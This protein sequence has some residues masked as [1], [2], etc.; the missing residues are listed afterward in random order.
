[1]SISNNAT[2]LRPGVC[3]SSTRPTTPYEGQVIYETDTDKVLIWN[4]SAW[5]MLNQKTQN[6]EGLELIDVTPLTSGSSKTISAFSSTYD[7]YRVVI[8]FVA[9]VA[10]SAYAYVRL[11]G[12]A[13]NH[14]MSGEYSTWNSPTRTGDNGADGYAFLF[15]TAQSSA[16][17]IDIMCPNLAQYSYMF[18]QGAGAD[19]TSTTRI[20]V[21]NTTQYTSYDF[22]LGGSGTFTSGNIV[23]YGYRKAI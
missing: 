13:T 16:A 5:V 22:L 7:N 15:A 1:M 11:G 4:A 2:G 9:T 6:P 19:Y 3:T 20:R 17:V 8:N 10:S 23:T 12:S 18:C 14:S 21:A